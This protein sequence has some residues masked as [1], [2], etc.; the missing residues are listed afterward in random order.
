MLSASAHML[1]GLYVQFSFEKKIIYADG[2]FEVD[3]FRCS[4][5][6]FFRDNFCSFLYANDR[7][8]D[9]YVHLD[10]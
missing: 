5:L 6:F 2:C 10:V 3:L 9:G 4:F 8:S 1:S 7:Y